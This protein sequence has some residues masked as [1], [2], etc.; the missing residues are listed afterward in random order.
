MLTIAVGWMF[1]SL[2]NAWSEPV[3]FAQTELRPE[4]I[5][6]E[7]STAGISRNIPALIISVPSIALMENRKLFRRPIVRDFMLICDTF[8]VNGIGFTDI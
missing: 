5:V 8:A 7:A 2:L 6:N 1:N 4:A 3:A